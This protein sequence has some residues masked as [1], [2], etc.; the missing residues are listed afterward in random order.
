ME[1][2]G[3]KTFLLEGKEYW[4]VKQFGGFTHRSDVTIRSLVTKGNRIRK[5]KAKCLEGRSVF[6]EAEELIKARV[7]KKKILDVIKRL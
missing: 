5:L 4:T 7:S 3:E 1:I 6:I 2:Q